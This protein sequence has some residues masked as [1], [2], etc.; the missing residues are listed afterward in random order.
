[1]ELPCTTVQTP[2]F[3]KKYKIVICCRNDFSLYEKMEWLN[4]SKH[5]VDFKIEEDNVYFAFENAD[6][7]LVFKIKYSV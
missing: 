3:D 6:D 5:S 7:A 2:N 1:M 4:H